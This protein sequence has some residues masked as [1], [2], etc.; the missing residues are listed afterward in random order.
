M[1]LALIMA[2]ALL[3]L[4]ALAQEKPPKSDPKSL[5]AFEFRGH[6]I[7]EPIEK[8]FPYWAE[9]FR[10]RVRNR[11]PGCIKDRA[12]GTAVCN[13]LT[14]QKDPTIF[15][16]D[17]SVG[18]VS[19]E[20]LRYTF[21]DGKLHGVEMSFGFDATQA[22]HEMLVAKYGKPASEKI[23]LLGSIETRWAFREGNLLLTMNPGP[24][25]ASS[26]AFENP[27]ADPII[28]ERRA[29]VARQKAKGAF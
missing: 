20:Q 10:T 1:K 15:A 6:V 26:L 5:P 12:P 8:H 27:K 19:V 2:A 3:A 17:M 18:G 24:R 16:S 7:G 4:P 28:A 14:A 29:A 11:L 21:L 25:F 22:I 9:D 13:D 23:G